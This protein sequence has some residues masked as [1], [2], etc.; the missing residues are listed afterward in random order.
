MAGHKSMV[1]TDRYSHAEGI[2]DFAAARA[3]LEATVK[4]TTKVAGGAL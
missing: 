4:P 1:M 2:I 3:S